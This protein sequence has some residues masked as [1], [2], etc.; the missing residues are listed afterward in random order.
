VLEHHVEHPKSNVPEIQ[1]MGWNGVIH[2][3]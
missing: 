1:N 2:R 3:V